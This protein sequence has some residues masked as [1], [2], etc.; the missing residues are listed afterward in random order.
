MNIYESSELESTFI[1]IINDKKLNK[2]VCCIYRH[3]VMDLNEFNDYYLNELLHKISSENKAVIF[4]DRFN[5]DLMKYDD[6]HSANE[7]LDFYLHIY[8]FLI[9]YNQLDLEILAKY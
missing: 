8:F 5:I 7:F 4:L 3:S 9:L 2:L 6:H 1:E